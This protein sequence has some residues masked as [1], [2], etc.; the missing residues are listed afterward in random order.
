ME[1]KEAIEASLLETQLNVQIQEIIM[2]NGEWTLGRINIKGP[3]ETP[4][5]ASWDAYQFIGDEEKHLFR[6]RVKRVEIE[7]IP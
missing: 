7:I 3:I 1:A 5:G 4:D 2:G 6:F